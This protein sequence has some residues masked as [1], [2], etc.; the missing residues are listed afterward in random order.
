MRK[1]G[2]C[3]SALASAC[4]TVY[5]HV[6]PIRSPRGHLINPSQKEHMKNL[7]I[8]F[9]HMETSNAL[10]EHIER[11]VEHDLHDF[12]RIES[13]HVITDVQKHAH[14]CE[15]DIHAK[16]HLHIEGHAESDDMYKSVSQAVE[17]AARQL[18]KS[19][20]KMIDRHGHRV[21]LTDIEPRKV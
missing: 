15:V 14:R 8:T 6:W 21:R 17:K 11:T 18:R 7:E 19:R 10:R 9:R 2:K 13:V 20:D 5:N 12:T 4:S 1:H 3:I 16:G